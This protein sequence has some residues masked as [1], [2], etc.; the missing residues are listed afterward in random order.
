MFV[1]KVRDM[2]K[3]IRILFAVLMPCA[4]AAVFFFRDY[5]IGLKRYF[6]R[7]SFYSLTG[8]WCPGCG[9]TRSAEALLHGHILSSV[10]NNPLLPL[11][12]LV[13]I[14]AYIENLGVL[15]GKRI[16][17]L[18]ERKGVWITVSCLLAVFYILRNF[19]PALG[20]V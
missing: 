12:L 14:L 8:Y 2:T 13:L 3:R 20:P 15:A 4:A 16:K 6:G 18:P 1:R 17:L 5:L 19:I 11:L 10:R 9:N 7:C